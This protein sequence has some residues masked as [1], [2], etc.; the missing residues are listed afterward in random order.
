MLDQLDDA[1]LDD[2]PFGVVCLDETLTVVRMNRTESQA[3]G[4]QRWRAIG[5][6]YFGDV[7]PGPANRALAEHVQ[8]F[9][10]GRAA[11]ARIAHT[12]VRRAGADATEI[13]LS[14]GDGRVYLAI[15]R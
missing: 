1:D 15:R 9:L 10:A 4:I 7:A 14:R 13:E 3:A 6:S 8:M 12:F 5:R 2:L 11:E